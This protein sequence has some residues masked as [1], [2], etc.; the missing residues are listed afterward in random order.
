MKVRKTKQQQKWR[1]KPATKMLQQ[2]GQNN[3]ANLSPPFFFCKKNVKDGILTQKMKDVVFFKRALQQN[4]QRVK[5]SHLLTVATY[6]S[7]ILSDV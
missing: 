5:I 6:C 4:V 3:F 2:Y 1:H 7:G